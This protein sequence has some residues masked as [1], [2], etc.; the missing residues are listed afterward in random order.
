MQHTVSTP[1]SLHSSREWTS[2]WAIRYWSD[3]E[4]LRRVRQC[5][6][7][8]CRKGR[9]KGTESCNDSGKETLYFNVTTNIFVE[10]WELL[11]NVHMNKDKIEFCGTWCHVCTRSWRRAFAVSIRVT[12]LT[13]SLWTK[14]VRNSSDRTRQEWL[15][16]GNGLRL[17]VKKMSF[18]SNWGLP[19]LQPDKVG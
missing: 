13:F 16:E 10:G 11:I 2:F 3:S 12:P 19:I 9:R 14:C 4:D 1:V 5:R 7:D 17:Y 15:S 6:G 18:W 8:E